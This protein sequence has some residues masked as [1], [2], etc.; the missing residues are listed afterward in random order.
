MAAR[1]QNSEPL[2]VRARGAPLC[3]LRPAQSDEIEQARIVTHSSAAVM[4][5]SD[6]IRRRGLRCGLFDR[7][8]GD[9]DLMFHHAI[10]LPIKYG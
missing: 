4:V 10:G 5:R 3:Y 6:G 2:N 1:L 8:V 7:M 9:L